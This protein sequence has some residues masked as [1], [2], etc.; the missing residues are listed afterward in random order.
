MLKQRRAAAR[1]I[2]QGRSVWHKWQRRRCHSNDSATAAMFGVSSTVPDPHAAQPVWPASLACAAQHIAA[3]STAAACST[4]IVTGHTT[5]NVADVGGASVRL[6][7]DQPLREGGYLL[8][9]RPLAHERRWLP[10]IAGVPGPSQ[11]RLRPA[12]SIC[13]KPRT[14]HC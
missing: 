7:L 14:C 12:V 1:I 6:R 13:S 10:A 4:A 8:G 5:P 3:E 2:G 9:I 11:S